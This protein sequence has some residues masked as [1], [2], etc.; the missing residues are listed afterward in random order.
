MP[1]DSLK[2]SHTGLN[3]AIITM[4]GHLA[5]A[6]ATAEANLKKQWPGLTVE[7]HSADQWAGDKTALAACHEAIARADIIITTML[8]LED[9]VKLVSAQLAA[10]RDSCDAILCALSA[11]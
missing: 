1:L 2:S 10:R 7:L 4:D 5:G 9:H 8:F 3:L 6:A 11:A